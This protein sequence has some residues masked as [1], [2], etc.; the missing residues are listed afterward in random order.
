MGKIKK[1]AGILFTDGQSILLLLRSEGKNANTWGL[2]GGKSK[3]GE[4]DLETAIRETMEETGLEKVPGENFDS[5]TNDQTTKPYTAFLYQIDKQFTVKLNHEH[6]DAKW[7]NFKDLK[8]LN[9]HPKLKENLSKYLSKIRK[10]IS[11]FN[12][13]SILKDLESL[14]NFKF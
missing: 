2:P 14:F 1:A 13:W 9:L 8:S 7:V 12:E 3:S 6:T 5:V 10:K 4:S 11:H